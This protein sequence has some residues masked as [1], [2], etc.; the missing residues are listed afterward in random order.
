MKY[1]FTVITINFN[2]K[3]GL[4][5]T[6]QSVFMQTFTNFEFI[7]ID[8]GSTN[9]DLETLK[10]NDPKINYWVSEK[11]NGVYNAMNKGLEKANGEY[12]IFMNSGDLFFDEN[13]LEVVNQNLSNNFEIYFGNTMLIKEKTSC[14]EIPPSK[15]NFSFLFYKYINHQST[16]VKRTLFEKIFMFNEQSK[17]T[18][19]WE[20]LIV[21][22]CKMNVPY[23][24]INYTICN[25]NCFGISSN[26]SI[27]ETINI[28]K[29][30]TLQVHFPHF[31]EDYSKFLRIGIK[32]MEHFKTISE[33]KYKWKFLKFAMNL[34]K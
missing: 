5:A 18:S 32:R 27:V 4:E 17:I 3:T 9:G 16:F 29:L 6:L 33:N 22:I 11:D 24:Y 19:D 10:K 34:I 1:K 26:E 25:Y 15:I 23:K 21:A 8:G 31:Y 2:N 12:V 20:F 7:I 14:I 28:E 13:V 30:K